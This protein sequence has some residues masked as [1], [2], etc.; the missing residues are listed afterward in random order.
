M[1]ICA[2]RVSVRVSSDPSAAADA[3]VETIAIQ[4]KVGGPV[5][6]GTAL[7]ISP[8]VKY[9]YVLRLKNFVR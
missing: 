6:A 1:M 2:G 8:G 5:I 3:A 4:P 9:H 7:P